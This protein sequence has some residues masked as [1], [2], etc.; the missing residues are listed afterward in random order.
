[1]PT[2]HGQS[3]I[4][5]RHTSLY[6]SRYKYLPETKGK[7]LEEMLRYFQEITKASGSAG[8]PSGDVVGGLLSDRGACALSPPH[9]LYIVYLLEGSTRYSNLLLLSLFWV[10]CCLSACV[11]A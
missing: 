4:Y 2:P 7:S 3:L 10:C 5:N 6:S 11:R 1:M 9:N 8:S